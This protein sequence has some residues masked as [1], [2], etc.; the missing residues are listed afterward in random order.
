M[1]AD[2]IRDLAFDPSLWNRTWRSVFER[3]LSVDNIPR[4]RST[5]PALVDRVHRPSVSRNRHRMASDIESWT[6]DDLK[7][8]WSMGYAPNNCVLVVAGDVTE[9]Q[10][11][12]FAKKYLEPIPRKDPPPPV[13]TKE[14]EQR[15]E[16][17]LVLEKQDAASHAHDRIS[18]TGNCNAV[19]PA[20]QLLNS[21]LVQGRSS[22]LNQR[23][24]REGAIGRECFAGSAFD[25]GS[26]SKL[27]GILAL[28]P[29]RVEPGRLSLL[30]RKS[31][32]LVVKSGVTADE[33]AKAKSQFLVAF[34]RSAKT[35]AG[36]ANLIG[37]F[38]IFP[39]DR[40]AAR[41]ARRSRQSHRG[42]SAKGC[43]QYL[44][45][46]NR[47]VATLIPE[48]EKRRA[49]NEARAA[50]KCLAAALTAQQVKLPPFTK[51]KLSN[52]ATLILIPAPTAAVDR[53]RDR[54][55]RREADST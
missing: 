24:V 26:R 52:G 33:L 5:K 25:A 39:V 17:R 14:P 48:K 8:H 53:Q 32:N 40:K 49:R 22:R 43:C 28:S 2:R 31:W 41:L 18:H 7:R 37:Q 1:E 15:G 16:R 54:A 30:S 38:E 3:R 42:R 4:G 44:R 35:I 45:R 12:A 9:A 11:M 20:L 21:I 29:R 10:V 50:R 27:V 6:M 13:K 51:Q 23:L 19:T 34:Y 46:Q 47:T 55:R 36:K